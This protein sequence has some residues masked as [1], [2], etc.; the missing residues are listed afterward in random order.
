M[1]HPHLEVAEVVR[2]YGADYLARY[3]TVTSSAQRRVL[4]AVA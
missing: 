2:Q 4:Q 3:G 1:T